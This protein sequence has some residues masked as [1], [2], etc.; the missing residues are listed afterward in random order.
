MECFRFFLFIL[1][2]FFSSCGK[3]SP[4]SEDYGGNTRAEQTSNVAELK[5]VATLA[6]LTSTVANLSG[7]TIVTINETDVRTEL[8]MKELFQS[9][10]FGQFVFTSL[11][12][13]EVAT[14]YPVPEIINNS[15]EFKDFEFTDLATRESLLAA[16]NVVDP[17]NGDSV[18]LGG[19][20]LI[21]K[22]Y[23][24][25]F[26]TPVPEGASLIPIACGTL[27]KVSN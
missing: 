9:L 25:N 17:Q 20:S 6:P 11:T 23:V 26:F 4:F 19:K 18:E 2:L 7:T 21:V 24:T 5:Y 16:L 10:F 1:I 12:C 8:K 22:A 27:F 13:D 14:Q 3:D 15:N